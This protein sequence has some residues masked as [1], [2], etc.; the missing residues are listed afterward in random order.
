M[1]G[2][3]KQVL[4]GRLPNALIC[5]NR[6]ECHHMREEESLP[7]CYITF[8]VAEKV[9]FAVPLALFTICGGRGE[10]VG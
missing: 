6:Q 10:E 7:N 3:S 4:D 1:D 2:P 5:S 9:K 8:I